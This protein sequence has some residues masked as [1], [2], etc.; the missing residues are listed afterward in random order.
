MKI[1]NINNNNYSEMTYFS[2]KHVLYAINLT[3]NMIVTFDN[4]KNLSLWKINENKAILQFGDKISDKIDNLYPYDDESFISLSKFHLIVWTINFHDRVFTNLYSTTI[5]HVLDNRNVVEII[6]ILKIA[7]KLLVLIVHTEDAYHILRITLIFKNKTLDRIATTF[8][9][10]QNKNYEV[11]KLYAPLKRLPEIAR[12]SHNTI[13]ICYLQENLSICFM[14]VNLDDESQLEI[15]K[16]HIYF[17]HSELPFLK[18]SYIRQKKNKLHFIIYNYQTCSSYELH[19]LDY[20]NKCCDQ[21]YSSSMTDQFSDACLLTFGSYDL[22]IEKNSWLVSIFPVSSPS[23]NFFKEIIL[24]KLVI[25]NKLESINSLSMINQGLL[26][27]QEHLISINHALAKSLNEKEDAL[28]KAIRHNEAVE[29]IH[30]EELSNLEG[31]LLQANTTIGKLEQDLKSLTVKSDNQNIQIMHITE[32]NS[33]LRKE[34]SDCEN[35]LVEAKQYIAQLDSSLLE[36]NA[37]IQYLN[38]LIDVLT[39]QMKNEKNKTEMYMKRSKDFEQLYSVE[40]NLNVQ[41][42]FAYK[43]YYSI[44][45]KNSK[46]EEINDET[47]TTDDSLVFQ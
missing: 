5:E 42:K 12:L 21:V 13:I 38:Q 32:E 35:K 10:T 3:E 27:T 20:I 39:Q 29:L 41:N 28:K 47:T 44:P 30:K 19:I 18:I 36:K 26:T 31:I 17:S 16:K 6:K 22:I 1:S 24:Q 9:G 11:K 2:K 33:V 46:I 40:K 8:L 25:K 23:Y 4:D 37:T 15:S 43:D 7:P 14:L 45:R 34:K